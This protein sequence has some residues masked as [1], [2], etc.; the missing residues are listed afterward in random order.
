MFNVHR[1]L[2]TD[3][4]IYFTLGFELGL[5]LASQFV[6]RGSLKRLSTVALKWAAMDST[7]KR[8]RGRP[9]GVLG[10]RVLKEH[11]ETI[12]DG[13]PEPGTI[14]YARAAREKKIEQRRLESLREKKGHVG[15]SSSAT[16][17]SSVLV[18]FGNAS[19]M[20]HM[21][22]IVHQHLLAGIS[23]CWRDGVEAAD[24][25]VEHVLEDAMMT[26]SAAALSKQLETTKSV[27]G[28]RVLSIASALLCLSCYL[29]SL[30][31][32]TLK[33]TWARAEGRIVP[34][35]CCIKMRYDET[36]TRVRV[37][38]PKKANFNWLAFDCFPSRIPSS[39]E[40]LL[41]PDTVWLMNRAD[42]D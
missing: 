31:L 41:S 37:L 15:G 34:L 28:A 11:M 38:D 5:D 25:L 24:P 42:K 9:R 35:M 27:V 18:P 8:G 3:L 6:S 19:A 10:S 21:G 22:D 12:S 33:A 16:S 29:W 4:L 40:R 23:K 7:T 13:K 36:P 20:Q 17:A 14:E 32:W 30:M 1:L 39:F 26:T 2:Q